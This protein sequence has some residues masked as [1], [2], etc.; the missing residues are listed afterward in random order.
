M[1]VI[2]GITQVVWELIVSIMRYWEMQTFPG[3]VV[4]VE[5]Q[6]SPP[7]FILSSLWKLQTV[8]QV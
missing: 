3:L 7:H 1:Y 6:I 4:I 5:Y 8:S 2:S